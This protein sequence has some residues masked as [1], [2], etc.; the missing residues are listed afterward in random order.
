[1][2]HHKH[3]MI[4]ALTGTPGTGKSSVS[5]ILRRKYIIMNLNK[6]IQQHNFIYSCKYDER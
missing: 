4:V 3:L 5:K 1:M 6:I 2:E